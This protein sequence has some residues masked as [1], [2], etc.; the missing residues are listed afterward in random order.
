MANL[1]VLEGILLAEAARCAPFEV[2][3]GKLGAF[4]S[5]RRPRVIWVGVE[6]PAELGQFQRALDEATPAWATLRRA[7]LLSSPDPGRIS[8]NAG[9]D[10]VRR[11]GQVLEG[12]NIVKLGTMQI[13]NVNLYRSDLQPTGAVYTCLYSANFKVE[14]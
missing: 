9:N 10:E 1:E 7:R 5:T 13:Q 11:I 6:A 12:T 2:S 14:R 4:P 3:I 8:R